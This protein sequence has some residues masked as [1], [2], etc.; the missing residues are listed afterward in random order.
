MSKI[1][2]TYTK[3]KNGDRMTNA[4]I[5]TALDHFEKLADLL[6]ISGEAFRITFYEANHMYN[7][8]RDI[9]VARKLVLP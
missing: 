6:S 5:L 1:S 2:K 3:Y 4:E 8:L 7:N 9:A